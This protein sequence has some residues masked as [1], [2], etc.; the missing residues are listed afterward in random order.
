MLVKFM[1]SEY[2]PDIRMS[3]S[4]KL[5]TSLKKLPEIKRDFVSN[6]LLTRLS[7]TADSWEQRNIIEVLSCCLSPFQCKKLEAIL[8]NPNIDP[9][10]KALGLNLIERKNG[11]NL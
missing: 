4:S 9:R 3:A 6:A 8:T 1:S 7:I 10:V 11:K 5:I 2:P